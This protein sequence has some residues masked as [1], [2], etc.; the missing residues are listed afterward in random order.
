MLVFD[1]QEPVYLR[2]RGVYDGENNLNEIDQFCFQ[3]KAKRDKEAFLA[4]KKQMKWKTKPGWPQFEKWSKKYMTYFVVT[5][6]YYAIN[7]FF[8]WLY[9]RFDGRE[10]RPSLNK[11]IVSSK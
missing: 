8:I 3:G 7:I 6:S 11:Y 5:L 9:G 2:Y 1:K 4:S 10:K